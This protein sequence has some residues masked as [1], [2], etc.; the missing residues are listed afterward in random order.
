MAKSFQTIFMGAAG[1][2]ASI[3]DGPFWI[4]QQYGANE[5]ERYQDISSDSNNNII[6]GGTTK[7]DGAGGHDGLVTKYTN[8]GALTFTKTYGGASN[9]NLFGVEVDSSDN[10]YVSG[11][12]SAD[13]NTAKFNSSF[14]KQW[15]NTRTSTQ[16]PTAPFDTAQNSAIDAN[17]KIYSCGYARTQQASYD[18]GFWTRYDS[19]GS[20]FLSR[21]MIGSSTSVGYCIWYGMDVDASGNI[22]VA[23]ICNYSSGSADYVQVVAKY[24]SSA[25][26][27]WQ[28]RLSTHLG[29]NNGCALDSSGNIYTVGYS[30]QV[31]AGRTDAECI[32]A[33][34]NTSGTIQWQRAFGHTGS[35]VWTDIKILNDVIYCFGNTDQGPGANSWL[36]AQYDTSGNLNFSR[37]LGNTSSA[38]GVGTIST[39]MAFDS[40]GAML[41]CGYVNNLNDETA[42]MVKLPND[43]S[44]TGTYGTGDYQYTYADTSGFTAT[45]SS[46]TEGAATNVDSSIALSATSE[47]GDI[48]DAVLTEVSTSIP[49]S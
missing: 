25:A 2:V 43:G 27:Q 20:N 38:T 37:T 35:D 12:L 47:T 16:V 46:L 21:S 23:G 10:I 5:A 24:N 42:V 1:G 18:Q 31:H 11:A 9:D 17:N 44:L 32:L 36:I 41:L 33:K 4:N 40:T 39:K 28:R 7:S 19:D 48:A 6:V 3:G 29:R 45:N 30:G 14:V 22:F 26:L 8:E 15:Q 34:Y 49:S 13:F